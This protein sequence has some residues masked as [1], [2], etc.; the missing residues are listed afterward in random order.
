MWIHSETRPWHDKNI[1][2]I[3][4]HFSRVYIK[5][6]WHFQ[7]VPS[8][9]NHRKN[10]FQSRYHTIMT[11]SECLIDL[12]KT[13]IKQ[14]SHFHRVITKQ[15]IKHFFESLNVHLNRQK[16]SQTENSQL[17]VRLAYTHETDNFAINYSWIFMTGHWWLYGRKWPSIYPPLPKVILVPQNTQGTKKFKFSQPLAARYKKKFSPTKKIYLWV[18][19]YTMENKNTK[20]DYHEVVRV[21]DQKWEMVEITNTIVFFVW[22][23][24]SLFF[25]QGISKSHL[26][27]INLPKRPIPT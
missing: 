23:S 13:H 12:F 10:L 1:Q 6:Y 7:R 18:G 27:K 17:K 20:T 21:G 3:T 19:V 22:D 4:T 11:L 25:I 26:E 14:H 15:N 5:Q 9:L 8:K 2:S 24:C 16:K